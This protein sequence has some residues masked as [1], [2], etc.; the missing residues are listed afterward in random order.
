MAGGKIMFDIFKKKK[1][2]KQ[3][4]EEVCAFFNQVDRNIEDLRKNCNSGQMMELNDINQCLNIYHRTLNCAK[5]M[6][7]ERH[8]RKFDI[9]SN[10][11]K[12][13]IKSQ[14]IR[15]FRISDS[16]SGG[17]RG[18]EKGLE[19]LQEAILYNEAEFKAKVQEAVDYFGEDFLK[20]K[21]WVCP[22]NKISCINAMQGTVTVEDVL[23]K[24]ITDWTKLEIRYG[25]PQPY[26]HKMYNNNLPYIIDKY[27]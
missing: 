19:A 16:Y 26:Y 12:E 15:I 3:Y 25:H 9:K 14:L 6:L 4:K 2:Q 7:N 23:K 11:W 20:E 8:F 13:L 21:I 17:V 10:E 1:E 22:D 24:S 18:N 5:E 27:I